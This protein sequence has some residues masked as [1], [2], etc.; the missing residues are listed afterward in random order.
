MSMQLNKLAF[1][2]IELLVVIA[3]IGILSGLI[4]VSMNGTTQKAT[5]AKGQIF[6]SSLRNSLMS[7]LISEWKLDEIIGTVS[8]YTTP[9]SW[10]GGNEG[11]LYG[12]GGTQVLPQLQSS[13]C[14]SEKCFLFDGY[15]DN[16][17]FGNAVNLKSSQGTINYWLYPTDFT[18]GRGV[19]HIYEGANT[20]YL[21]NYI[22]SS[23]QIDLVIED[24]D[25]TYVNLVSSALPLNKWTNITWVQ[26]GVS[27]KLYING[28]LSTLTG[29]N[30]GSW[31][32]NHLSVF[33]TKLGLA[34]AYYKGSIDEIRVYDAAI[35]SSQIKEQYYCSLNSLFM[36]GGITK[37]EY[38]SRINEYAIK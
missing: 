30:S 22:N 7:N 25:A 38:L 26:N 21:R 36:N 24:G 31:W 33:T 4:V 14:V 11:T 32:T 28:E 1:T 20:D 2:L 27:I 16:V 6:S 12:T 29:I 8:P 13:N 3:V 37:E 18:G 35:S 15:D 9:D 5:I 34:W 23:G 19:F 10:S 17:V